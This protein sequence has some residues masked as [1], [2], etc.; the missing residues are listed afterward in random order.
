[1]SEF[2]GENFSA[3]ICGLTVV[4]VVIV[5]VDVVVEVDSTVK[6]SNPA[7]ISETTSGSSTRIVSSSFKLS[8]S[9]K[10]SKFSTFSSSSFSMTDEDLLDGRFQFLTL[11]FPAKTLFLH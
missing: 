2:D 5:V 10:L 4:D 9:L 6:G 11:G 1:M 3:F 8:C 7:M